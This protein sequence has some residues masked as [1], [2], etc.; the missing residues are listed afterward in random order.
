MTTTEG[1]E[2][3]FGM[4]LVEFCRFRTEG[5]TDAPL[6]RR[7]RRKDSIEQSGCD[8]V[9]NPSILRI[10]GLGFIT[11]MLVSFAGTGHPFPS[12]TLAIHEE[13][14]RMKGPGVVSTQIVDMVHHGGGPPVLISI[15]ISEVGFALGQG[16]EIFPVRLQ[17]EKVRG[18]DPS[19][20]RRLLGENRT[21][22]EIKAEIEGAEGAYSYRGNV[23]LGHAHYLLEDLN[24]TSDELNTTLEADLMEPA[25][26]WCAIPMGPEPELELAGKIFVETR[27]ENESRISVGSLVIFTGLYA[28]SYALVL[29]SSFGAGWEMTSCSPWTWTEGP[30]G[31]EVLGLFEGRDWTGSPAWGRPGR[32]VSILET[33][34]SGPE[35][36]DISPPL[37]PG[38]WAGG[39][40]FEPEP[41]D[42]ILRDLGCGGRCPD[43]GIPGWDDG[44]VFDMMAYGH[45]RLS[46]LSERFWI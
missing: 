36:M 39:C 9:M 11:L 3:L 46:P 10:L 20:V 8:R 4:D 45:S 41:Y 43:L 33:I 19:R 27:I 15:V 44:D 24:V 2:H 37:C 31:L 13:V 35:L 26:G 1:K 17:V 32:E 28:G 23:R 38:C 22:G 12:E 14:V 21:L 18:L 40:P 29:D 6:Q 34:F 30:T 5:L 7:L 16:D 25:W 42:M